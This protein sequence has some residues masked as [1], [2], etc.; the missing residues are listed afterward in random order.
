MHPWEL[1]SGCV[2]ALVAA[3]LGTYAAF[4][5]CQKGPI[6]TNT[7]LI[8]NKEAR[9]RADKKAEYRLAAIVFGGL[10]VIFA[11]LA[12][13]I[14]TDWNWPYIPVG[15]L[16]LFIIVYAIADAVKTET[17]RRG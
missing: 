12:L 4:A 15:I 8:L 16:S 6:L 5:A 13:A 1:A 11:F 14:L 3:A 7:Y 10:S 9:R 2:F 17:R